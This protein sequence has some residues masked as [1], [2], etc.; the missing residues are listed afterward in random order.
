MIAL[1]PTNAWRCGVVGARLRGGGVV[2]IIIGMLPVTWATA[3]VVVDVVMTSIVV[4]TSDTIFSSSLS[5]GGVAGARI[6]AFIFV[7]A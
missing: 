6:S 5:V 1:F 3:A 4:V 2:G 7:R